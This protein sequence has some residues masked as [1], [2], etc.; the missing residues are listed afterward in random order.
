VSV[1]LRALVGVVVG[2]L[3]GGCGFPALAGALEVEPSSFQIVSA[4]QQAGAHV[5]TTVS[6]G[7]KLNS[8]GA[9]G[10]LERSAEVVFPLGFAGYPANAKTCTAVQLQDKECPPASQIGTIE[11]VFRIARGALYHVRGGLF[12]MV[13][14]PYLSTVY[15]YG[16]L[17]A[18]GQILWAVGPEYKLRSWA[19]NL[20][21]GVE[22]LGQTLTA[23]GV[24]AA[25]V[26]D[27]E[28]GNEFLCTAFN[29]VTQ[30]ED[31][32]GGNHVSEESPEPYVVS[33][34]QCTLPG[35]PALE[36]ELRKVESWAGELAPLVRTIVPAFTGC[37]KL[38]FAPTLS[39][40]PEVT[41]A[42][43]PTGYSVILRVPQT[44]GAKGLATAD[45]KD[46]V[47]KLPEGVVLSPSA[48][49]G[50]VS[51]SE[52][53]VGYGNENPVEC[54]IASKLGNVSVVTP[55]LTGELKGGLY[56]GGPPSG[57]IREPPFTAYLTF[58][59]HGVLV[60]I[61]GTVTPNPVTGQVVTTFDEN[62]ELPFSELKLQLNGGSRA[63]VANPHVCG[64]YHAESVFTPWSTPFEPDVTQLSYPF[65]ITGCPP[66]RFQPSF[67]AS[68]LSNQAGGYSTMRVFFSREDADEELGGLTVTMPPGVSGNL[69]KVPVC[70]EP[71][72]AEGTCPE[73]SQ[74]GEVTAGAG[75]GPEPVFIKGGKVFLTGPYDGAPFGLSIDVSETAG[76]LDLGTGA[77]NCQV[78]RATVNINPVT[79]QITVSNGALP[80]IRDGIPFQVKSVDV[81][82]NRPGFVFNPTNCE[83]MTVN[84]TISSIHSRLAQVSSH[85]QVTN[86]E[87][88]G[89]KPHFTVSTSGKTSRSEGASLS[90]KLTYPEVGGHSILAGG[91]A[92][93]AKVKVEL[94]KQL[95]SRLS[96]LQ[97]A[98]T[99]NVF[100]ANPAN[101]PAASRIGYGKATTPIFPGSLTGPAFFVSNGNAKF[102]E[103]I[104]VL[105][106]DNVTIDLHGETF[107]NSEGITSTTF[108]TVPD[109]P[110]G[111]FTIVLPEGPESALAANGNLCNTPLAMPTYFVAQNGAE[112]HEN[113]PIAV[114]GCRAA[115]SVLHHSSTGKRATVVVKVPSAGKLLAS[116]VG[117]SKTT[118][119]VGKAGAVSVNLTLS[120]GEQQLL[121]RHQGRKLAAHVALRFTSNDGQTLSGSVM[122]LLG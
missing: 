5:D 46:A 7:Y 86:C 38:K 90:A 43:T 14:P 79:A 114:T 19:E 95:P 78:V 122:V 76:P 68:M 50:L 69:A 57:L 53:Q 107:I 31:C 10:Q 110:V 27:S 92:N 28:R 36:A 85:F 44:E 35:E 54:P 20:V 94:P 104:I 41:Q 51:C 112:Y 84:G 102:P 67:S 93:I 4:G 88:L 118:R 121:A 99:Q 32:S 6:F 40:A 119:M 60:K 91:F 11:S 8:E 62:P 80:T 98:C 103:L 18:S 12:N 89:F 22:L 83:P 1:R 111:T 37:D 75:P 39:V 49:T 81:D 117:L 73:S 70:E 61:R 17:L 96:T 33:P 120:R 24:P 113:T 116:G 105:Q 101:C 42:T 26:H 115:I 52:E 23:W 64:E 59:G 45:L 13:P 66:A 74:I 29:E 65:P 58:A 25:E 2:V 47:V 48:A 87:G 82:I 15:G 100:N 63:T 16:L 108:A 77:C 3:A 21:T 71:Q 72:A 30:P 34:T 106:G 109:V 9:L 56:L 55:S 97:K